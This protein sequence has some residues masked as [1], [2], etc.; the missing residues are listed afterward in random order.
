MADSESILQLGIEAA[1]AGDKAEARELFR[2]VTREDPDN[3]QGWMWLAGVAEDRDEKR[4]ALQRAVQIEPNNQLAKK[5]LAALGGA[6]AAM[7]PASAQ[8]TEA[9]SATTEAAP[10]AVPT[11]VPT[12]SSTTVTPPDKPSTSV[13]PPPKS[14]TTVTPPLEPANTITPAAQFVVS[15]SEPVPVPVE[16]IPVEPATARTGSQDDLDFADSLDSLDVYEQSVGDSGARTYDAPASGDTTYVPPDFGDDEFDL[17]DY[18]NRPRVTADD[19]AVMERE[20]GGTVVVEDEPERSRGLPRWLV[21]LVGLLSVVII[22]FFLLQQCSSTNSTAGVGTRTPAGNGTT[23]ASGRTASSVAI[24][25]QASVTAGGTSATSSVGGN[26]TASPVG[27]GETQI[28][29]SGGPSTT[30]QGITD[31]A[32]SIVIEPGTSAT[33]GTN[34]TDTSVA[35]TSA[36]AIVIE[37]GASATGQGTTAIVIEPSAAA[38]ALAVTPSTV[39]GGPDVSTT[40]QGGAATQIIIEPGATTTAP[41]ANETLVA[42][43]PS[44]TQA[45]S[46]PETAVPAPATTLPAPGGP[47]DVA[48]ANPALVPPT[49]R[50]VAGN[51]NFVWDYGYGPLKI[52]STNPYGGTRPSRGQWLVLTIATANT[53]GQP[54][55]IPDGFFVLKDGQNRVYDFNRAA[56]ADWLNRFGRGVAADTSADSPFNA[57][58]ESV[59]LLFD[60]PPDANN[61]VLFSRDNPGQGYLVR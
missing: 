10:P 23:V 31:T 43:E 28:V 34:T 48:N 29:I 53:D 50:I 27:A 39:A 4:A 11:P 25:G 17:S 40:V 8:S 49:Q 52:T 32:T 45:A 41:A 33:V 19:V 59:V 2:L 30:A 7:P 21:P 12:K 6:R 18:Q 42:A 38:T 15:E 5:G 16:P 57:T 37:P 36:T 3:A 13:T 46:A 9:A 56:S 51:W 24:A 55:Q 20:R 1:R 58:S 60:V 44:A 22:G 14:P 35:G 54:Q 26:T 61:L 47:G